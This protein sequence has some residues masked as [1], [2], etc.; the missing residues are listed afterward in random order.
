MSPPNTWYFSKNFCSDQR[1][2]IRKI[3]VVVVVLNC[4]ICN[5]A[6]CAFCN[7]DFYFAAR[8]I[9]VTP[10]ILKRVATIFQQQRQMQRWYFCSN[11]PFDSSFSSWLGVNTVFDSLIRGQLSK[12]CVACKVGEEGQ[13]EEGRRKRNFKTFLFWSY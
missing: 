2:F 3:V 5:F 9:I 1:S 12:C 6:T 4:F 13:E 11:P 10:A 8:N 7:W